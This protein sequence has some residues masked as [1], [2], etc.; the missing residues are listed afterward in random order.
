MNK[1]KK[2][3]STKVNLAGI[4]VHIP[5]CIK[6]CS[7]CNFFSI[8]DLSYTDSFMEAL[9]Q[10]MSLIRKDSLQF[11]TLYIGGGTPSLLGISLVNQII[12][13]AHQFF[14]MLPDTEITMEINPGTVNLDRLK[15]YRDAG[16]NRLNIGVQSFQLE[17][18]KFLGRL[19]SSREAKQ[20]IKQ[21]QQAGFANIG[22][23]LIYGIPNQ[24]PKAWLD[25]LKTATDMAPDHL[26]C[27]MLTYESETPLAR[28]LQSGRFRPMSESLVANL[29]ETTI[30]FLN[31]SGYVHYEISNFERSTS[32]ESESKR[33]RHNQKYWLLAPYLGLGPSAHSFIEPVRWWNCRSV[34]NYIQKLEAGRLPLEDSEVLTSE[35]NMLEAIYLGLR[36]ADGIDINGFNRRFGVHFIN[37]FETTIAD[38]KKERLITMTRNRCALTRKG[39]LFLDTIASMFL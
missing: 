19:H 25:D 22:I 5:F 15:G 12:D 8:T 14:K 16:V 27:Y 4:Y 21:A 24:T 6:K 36:Q 38:L 29:F 20:V 37:K 3:I 33:S 18:L 10:E 11:D 34:N 1:M 13:T 17:N 30:N 9:M 31:E 7:Y 28:N 39:M 32:N 2:S 35:Q 23:D 26:S